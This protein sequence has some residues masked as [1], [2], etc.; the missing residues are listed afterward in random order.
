MQ[1]YMG[2]AL[3]KV[4]LGPPGSY[5]EASWGSWRPFRA[6]AGSGEGP[7]DL[8]EGSKRAPEPKQSSSR[9]SQERYKVV[10]E[11]SYGLFVALKTRL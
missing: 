8:L 10:Q 1:N 7:G 5:F 11:G 2:T 3:S 6:K 4:I 9:G